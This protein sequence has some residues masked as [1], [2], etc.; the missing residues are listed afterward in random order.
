[1]RSPTRTISE[2]CE[3]IQPLDEVAMAA[4]QKRQ[5]LLTK[6]QGSLGRLEPLSVQ[7]AGILASPLPRVEHK[8]VLVMAGD[9][10]I[11]AEGVSAYPPEVT[12]QMV[13]NFLGGGAA[14]NVLAR[15]AG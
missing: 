12:A 1:M 10:G 4:A 13:L 2:T 11:A 15:Q 6:P 7:L 14:V 3:R 8:V 9:H 5:D